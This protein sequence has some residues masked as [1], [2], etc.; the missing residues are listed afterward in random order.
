MRRHVLQALSAAAAASAA[1]FMTAGISPGASAAT[2]AKA[3]AGAVVA[4]SSQAGY[5]TGGGRHFRFIQSTVKVSPARTATQF[6]GVILGGRDHLVDT[7]YLMVKAGGG[8]NSVICS[9]KAPPPFTAT[10]NSGI[11][12]LAKLSPGVGDMLRLSIYYNPGTRYI[13]FTAV[14]TTKGVSQ[15]RSFPYAQEY[16]SAAEAAVFAF[17]YTAPVATDFRLW[18]F[19]NTH[20]TTYSGVKGSLLGAWATSKIVAVKSS[21]AVVM[22]PSVLFSSGADFNVLRR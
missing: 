18:S 12:T 5:V 6:A 15:T 22:G 14:D 10:H 1:V 2:A 9:F 3:A 20:V 17:G 16:Y 4:T 21:G 7:L 11:D 13:S 8:A 19:T